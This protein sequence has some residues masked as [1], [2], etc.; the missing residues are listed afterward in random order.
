MLFAVIFLTEGE[1]RALI[2]DFCLPSATYATMALR[3]ILKVD[4]S[5]LHQA[6]LNSYIL[7]KK[8]GDKEEPKTNA[9]AQDG[10]TCTSTQNESA[11]TG[12]G[13]TLEVESNTETNQEDSS[14]GATKRKAD[15]ITEEADG[16]ET[17][18]DAVAEAKKVKLEGET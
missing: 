8:A 3:E 11:K 2:L 15:D 12:E 13:S 6:S 7:G 16:Q 10:E 9:A 18:A 14:T 5:S 4:T 1:Y 17:D